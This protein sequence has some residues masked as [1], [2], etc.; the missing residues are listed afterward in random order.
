MNRLRTRENNS[1]LVTNTSL[2]NQ[3][4]RLNRMAPLMAYITQFK[5]H[6]RHHAK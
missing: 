6:R 5:R 1:E 2:V 4:L 3:K